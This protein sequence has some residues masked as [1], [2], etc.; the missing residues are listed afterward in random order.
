ML[1]PS[2]RIPL[3]PLGAA[4]TTP[5]SSASRKPMDM[6][7]GGSG[8][9]NPLA[10]SAMVAPTKPGGAATTATEHTGAPT[11]A[12]GLILDRSNCCSRYMALF[13]Q[14]DQ[15]VHDED[16]GGRDHHQL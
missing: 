3:D 10:A 13:P 14:L 6:P 5:C 12:G 2:S 15:G 1:N 7:A 4:T 11:M 16:H 9:A 8:I